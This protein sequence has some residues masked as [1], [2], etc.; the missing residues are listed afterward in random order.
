M[1][2]HYSLKTR[3]GCLTWK[4]PSTDYGRSKQL[5]NVEYFHNFGSMMMMQQGHMKLNPELSQ[6]KQHSTRRSRIF[7]PAVWISS[8]GRNQ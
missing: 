3:R 2:L 6:H 8:E 5:E 1:Y 4:S 7:S